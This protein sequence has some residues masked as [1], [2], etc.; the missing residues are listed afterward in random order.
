[1]DERKA[2]GYLVLHNIV[3]LYIQGAYK[4]SEYFAKQFI[5]HLKDECLQFHSNVKCI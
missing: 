3:I 2:A 1:M 5:Y 4:L